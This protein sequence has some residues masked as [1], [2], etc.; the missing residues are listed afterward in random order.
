MLTNT[1]KAKKDWCLNTIWQMK[2]TGLEP[3]GLLTA[4]F[5]RYIKSEITFYQLCSIIRDDA[6]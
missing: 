1:T 2:L 3:S 5:S 6:E 4:A